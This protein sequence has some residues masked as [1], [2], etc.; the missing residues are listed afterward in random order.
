[1]V[2]KLNPV[3]RI[4]LR[5]TVGLVGRAPNKSLKLTVDSILVALPLHCG[6]FNGSL[7]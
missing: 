1:M 5:K 7:A 6:A 4:S 2:K 3:L